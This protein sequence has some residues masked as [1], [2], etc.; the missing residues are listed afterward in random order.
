MFLPPARPH[1][2]NSKTAAMVKN[3]MGAAGQN[4]LGAEF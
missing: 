4:V 2:L 3:A 1:F